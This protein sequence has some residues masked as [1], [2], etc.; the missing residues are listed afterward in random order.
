MRALTI[1]LVAAIAA[2]A[3]LTAADSI[4]DSVGGHHGRMAVRPVSAQCTLSPTNGTIVRAIG[5]RIYRLNVPVGLTGTSV[6]LL[7]A[8]HGNASNAKDFEQ[9]SGWTPYAATHGF[10]V[11]YPQGNANNQVLNPGNGLVGNDW[12]FQQDSID[13]T[14]LRQVVADIEATWCIDTTRVYSSGWSDGGLMSQRLACDAS[15]VFADVTSWEGADPTLPNPTLRYPSTGSPCNPARPISVGIFGGQIDPI[16]DPVVDQANSAAWVYRDGCP[17]APAVSSDSY[18][19]S[20][21]F[22]PCRNGTVVQNRI[23]N[24]QTHVWP[25]GAIGQDLRDR[26]WG[27]M[28]AATLP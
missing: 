22:R 28:T 2:I 14:F 25:T 21:D 27:F 4:R 26:L 5:T 6:P 8:E 20:N 7:V 10:I 17:A 11:A 16:S 3:V 23:E 12:E 9:V 1:C 24:G 18:G 13:V 15:D 19:T